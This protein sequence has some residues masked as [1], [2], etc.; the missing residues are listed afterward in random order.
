MYAHSSISNEWSSIKTKKTNACALFSEICNVGSR[1]ESS[2]KR[3][4]WKISINNQQEHEISL[5]HSLASGKKIIRVD[6]TIIH[7]S[8]SLLLGEWDYTFHVKGNHL[9]HLMIKP[10]LELNDM[11][12]LIIDGVS[13]RRLPTGNDGIKFKFQEKS[14]YYD[15]PPSMYQSQQ[16]HSQTSYSDITNYYNSSPRSSISS[17]GSTDFNL[18]KDV[19]LG[20][21][22]C[23]ACTFINEKPHG[24][25]C[26]ACLS[27]RNSRIFQ[28]DDN[29]V[30]LI[31]STSAKS[32][33]N[34]KKQESYEMK[35][36][37]KDINIDLN[38]KINENNSKKDIENEKKKKKKK[39]L[40]HLIHQIKRKIQNSL[41]NNI[42]ND[43]NNIL[44]SNK[45][46]TNALNDLDFSIPKIKPSSSHNND[47]ALILKPSLSNISQNKDQ[48]NNL[49]SSDFNSFNLMNTSNPMKATNKNLSNNFL[50][51]EESTTL[52]PINMDKQIMP[53]SMPLSISINNQKQQ[54]L[55]FSNNNNNNNINNQNGTSQSSFQSYNN[56]I[57]HNTQNSND[58]NSNIAS[59]HLVNQKYNHNY[60]PFANLQ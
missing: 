43:N 27:P 33:L 18:L 48:I 20:S 35:N 46:L 60:D 52:S 4:T 40:F 11:Y 13:F 19:S 42:K 32:N 36:N 57:N 15:D 47:S 38:L 22:T 7:Q 44:S 23:R 16:T 12:D 24:L 1:I 26:D 37:S 2:K 25:V 56:N 5:T 28:N 51:I 55:S 6:G 29:N 8:K 34:E 3:I 9:L 53:L 30:D 54:S 59:I 58:L 17:T 45:E 31:K 39:Y 50:S 41:N 21:W 10:S 14:R 49:W